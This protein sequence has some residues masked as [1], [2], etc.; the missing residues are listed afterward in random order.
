[1]MGALAEY[2]NKLPSTTFFWLDYM[3]LRQLQPDFDIDRIRKLIRDIGFT[4]AEVYHVDPFTFHALPIPPYLKRTFCIFELAATVQ[5]GATLIFK[6]NFASQ[7]VM[8][9]LKEHPIDAAAAACWN[10][11]H[12]TLIKN[13]IASTIGF[14]AFNKVLTD[15]VISGALKSDR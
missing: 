13:D 5:E 12:D 4:I 3:T 14:D 1:M 6:G 11:E 8:Q 2:H 7:H 15:A 10:N 9:F